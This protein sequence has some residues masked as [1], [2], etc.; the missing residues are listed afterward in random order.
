MCK[1]NCIIERWKIG[2][3]ALLFYPKLE[4]HTHGI[5]ERWKI[6][7]DALLFYPKIWF[8]SLLLKF[9]LIKDV[10]IRFGLRNYHDPRNHIGR[11]QFPMRLSDQF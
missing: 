5:I 10:V 3:D 4:F 9:I 2:H 6:G 11:G 7:N 8:D 1:R